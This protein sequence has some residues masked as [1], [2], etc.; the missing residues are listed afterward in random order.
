ML[1]IIPAQLAELSEPINARVM[2][3]LA[4]RWKAMG[5]ADRALYTAP[6]APVR[7]PLFHFFSC[8]TIA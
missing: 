7:R 1:T 3:E 8:C 4:A 6:V 5:A 2:S